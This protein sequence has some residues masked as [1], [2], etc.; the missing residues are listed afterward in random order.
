MKDNAVR[1]AEQVDIDAIFASLRLSNSG[2]RDFLKKFRRAVLSGDWETA[3]NTIIKQ[4][5][6]IKGARA[7]LKNKSKYDPNKWI[8]G[9]HLDYRFTDAKRLIKDI[10]KGGSHV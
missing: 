7:K 1:F 8:G 10:K 3:D 6:R 2:L 4:E 5:V 9:Y